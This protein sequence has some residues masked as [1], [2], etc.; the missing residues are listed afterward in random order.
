MSVR[1]LIVRLLACSI[2]FISSAS[3]FAIS[4]WMTDQPAVQLSIRPSDLEVVSQNPPAFNW[5]H[6]NT[7]GTAYML[8]LN[9][10]TGQITAFNTAA[11]WF[12]PNKTFAPGTYRWRVFSSLGRSEWRTFTITAD[13]R[14]Y[15][16]PKDWLLANSAAVKKM[17]P[18]FLP[19]A[20]ELAVWQNQL[21]SVRLSDWNKLKSRVQLNFTSVPLIEPSQ[22]FD[23]QSTGVLDLAK[24]FN[25]ED[26]K[27]IESSLVWAIDKDPAA[28]EDARQRALS[29]ARWDV[30]GVSA[31]E[32]SHHVPRRILWAL[33]LSYDLLSSGLSN[34]EKGLIKSAIVARMQQLDASLFGSK[35]S[36]ER[37]PYDSHNLVSLYAMAASTALMAGDDASIDVLYK[38]YL[39]WSLAYLSPWGGADGGYANGTAY[40]LWSNDDSIM[41]WDAIYRT[42]KINPYATDWLYNLANFWAYFMP[43]GAP[44]GVSGEAAE[45][46][47]S[48]RQFKELAGR[49]QNP[50]GSW[51]AYQSF[52]ADDPATVK[53]LLPPQLSVPVI[54][55]PVNTP[56]SQLFK[57]IGLAAL[58][59]NLEDRSRT[60]LYFKNSPFGSYNHSHADQGAF[61]LDVRGRR[62]AI[63]SGFYDWYGSEHWKNWYIQTRA[64]NAITVDGGQGQK[65]QS[66]DPQANISTFIDKAEYSIVQA[67][68]KNAY[69]GLLKKSK[70]SIVFERSGLILISDELASDVARQWEWNIHGL[71]AYQNKSGYIE[72]EYDGVRICIKQLAGADTSFSQTDT[73]TSSPALPQY[74]KQYHGTF[75]TNQKM[76]DN[77]FVFLIDVDC[78]RV[79]Q[80][81]TVITADQININ[82]DNLTVQFKKDALPLVNYSVSS[83][84]TLSRFK[85]DVSNEVND[86]KVVNKIAIEQPVLLTPKVASVPV[87]VNDSAVSQSVVK[88][89]PYKKK[90]KFIWF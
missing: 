37:N 63:D 89:A 24:Y 55:L 57:S 56:S 33:V 73:F 9:D 78:T 2:I 6:I 76:T 45:S 44:A 23:Y 79:D 38:R 65:T 7:L 8:Q 81:Q 29:L 20:A 21:H 22:S 16:I 53:R 15:G 11:N 18:K 49:N 1:K 59:S 47:F 19:D 85:I 46:P 83:G 67:D 84:T 25:N 66:M 77:W 50:L 26:W 4:D 12:L 42:T 87:L 5:P 68:T 64:H 62:M 80:I 28:F 71:S 10:P 52:R 82:V 32:P 17:R 51:L 90:K 30:N 70:R 14:Q 61:V 43:P 35:R 58:H 72:Q 36:L 54:D 39:P 34:Y 74:A 40:S 31:Y 75:F 13:A 41:Y 3:S 60:S 88:S 27:I 86:P 48:S 69:S